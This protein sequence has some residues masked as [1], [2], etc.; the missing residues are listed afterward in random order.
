MKLDAAVNGQNKA[1]HGHLMM[2][3]PNEVEGNDVLQFALK[4]DGA[5]AQEHNEG[6]AE[7]R[8]ERLERDGAYRVEEPITKFTR[9]FKPRFSDKVHEV[10]A[11]DGGTVIDT[12][13]NRHSTKFVQAV[14]KSSANVRSTQFTRG[15]SAQVEQKKRRLLQNYATS[16]AALIRAAGGEL[17]LWRIGDRLK[18]MG[19]GFSIAARE[20]GLNQKGV[21]ASFLRA[22]PERFELNI[23][24]GGGKA[25]VKLR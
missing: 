4:Q 5:R 13:G 19:P 3:A 11:V 25:T 20:A 16:V 23:P 24:R 12:E 1:P 2:S 15:G 6:I 10:A 21:I 14:P 8:A 18:R 22:F 17:E 7:K 9:S